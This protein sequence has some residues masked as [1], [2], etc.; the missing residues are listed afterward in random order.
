MV[1]VCNPGFEVPQHLNLEP[2]HRHDP[3]VIAL[4]LV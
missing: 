3:V 2:P 4:A 1:N